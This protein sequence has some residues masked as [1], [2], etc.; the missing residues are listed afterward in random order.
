MPRVIPPN[1][2]TMGQLRPAQ[3]GAYAGNF[4][5]KVIERRAMACGRIYSLST[6]NSPESYLEGSSQAGIVVINF[7]SMPDNIELS[8]AA[9]YTVT[10]TPVHPDGIHVY[11]HTEPIEIPMSFKV[12]AFDD[13]CP[14]GCLSL[15]KIAGQLH[16]LTL[17]IGD[18]SYA[19]SAAFGA[20]GSATAKNSEADQAASAG[21]VS[22]DTA[23]TFSKAN[24]KF[25]VACRLELMYSKNNAPGISCVGYVK[26]AKAVFGGPYLRTQDGAYNLPSTLDVSFVFVHR[27]A[28]TNMFAGSF[29]ASG[30]SATFTPQIQAYADTVK[31]MLYNTHGLV[32]DYRSDNRTA[33][34]YSGF[35]T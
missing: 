11:K 30:L 34:T 35:N 13:Y 29:T 23:G 12:H 31:T 4:N 27:P 2:V 1:I 9:V 14:Q 22:T 6:S 3:V 19:A 20:S 33:I 24:V 8:R 25:P 18:S 16:A 7:P 10:N 26:S 21:A 15:L 5:P 28:H 17:P 32:R